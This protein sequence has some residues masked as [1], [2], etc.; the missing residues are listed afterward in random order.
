MQPEVLDHGH[1]LRL[2]ADQP[3][4]AAPAAQAARDHR[5]I[6]HQRAVGEHQFAEV[7]D[8]ILVRAQGPNEGLSAEALGV[9]VFITRTPEDWR[10]VAE[11][12]DGETLQKSRPLVWS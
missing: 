3:E 7:D 11:F 5:Q 1:D 8:D 4:R 9:A 12:D 10:A 2:G 6:R